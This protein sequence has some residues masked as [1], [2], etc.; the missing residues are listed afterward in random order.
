MMDY[1]EN[2]NGFDAILA[3]SP[4]PQKSSPSRMSPEDF[5]AKKKAQREAI[6][7]MVEQMTTAVSTNGQR[8]Q[9]YLDLQARLENYSV[10]NGLLI[11]SQCPQATQ[12]R[13][14][15][16]W[17][18]K[19]AMV[20]RGQ[21][22]ISIL[23]PGRQYTTADGRIGTYYEVKSVF[24]ISQTNAATIEK[25][26]VYDYNTMTL[27]LIAK[28][29]VPINMV[30]RQSGGAAY[31]AASRKI[32]VQRGMDFDSM[33]CCVSAALAQ[34]EIHLR[35]ENPCSPVATF[36]SYCVSYMMCKKYGLDVTRYNFSPMPDYM[37]AETKVVRGELNRLHEVFKTMAIRMDRSLSQS[38]RSAPTQEAR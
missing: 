15:D 19:G 28:R 34:A 7:S 35:G 14:F 11:L 1:A 27:A 29:P 9:A 18:M 33:F 6:Y 4:Q 13:D 12:L 24:D 16:G 23:E 32:T 30:D 3:N 2:Y 10:N 26:P 25:K 5:A 38:H 8:F 31:D 21:Q 17:R 37:A 22:G 20:K 36:R